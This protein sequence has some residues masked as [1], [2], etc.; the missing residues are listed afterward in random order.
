MNKAD[1][2]RDIHKNAHYNQIVRELTKKA[3]SS[4]NPDSSVSVSYVTVSEYTLC[5]LKDQGFSITLVDM[6]N[7]TVHRIS[8]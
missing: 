2:I 3:K 5:K 4:I 8:L 6:K 7:Y 1:K